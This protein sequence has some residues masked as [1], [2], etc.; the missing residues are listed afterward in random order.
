MEKRVKATNGNT[1]VLH[2]TVKLGHSITDKNHPNA[3][4]EI[5]VLHNTE[6]PA[7]ISSTGK[8]EYYF[9][10]IFKGTTSQVI[11][12]L[13]KDQIGLPPDKSSLMEGRS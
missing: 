1:Y 10:G 7:F 2:K 3:Y 5:W 4:D 8:K 6:G 11:K 13:K 9:W 12:D